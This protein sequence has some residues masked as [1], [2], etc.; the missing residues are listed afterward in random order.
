MGEYQLSFNPA[1]SRDLLSAGEA[2]RAMKKGR[3]ARQRQASSALVITLLGIVLLTIVVVAF[4]QT[5]S[6][7]LTTAKSYAD[8]RRATL[9]AQAG[10]DTAVAQISLAT[11]TNLA[12]V[13]GLTNYP[14]PNF[15]LTVIGAGNLTN[16]DQM[17][18]MVSGPIG[19]LTTFGVPGFSA[20]FN[21]Y[22]SARTNSPPQT[23]DVNVYTN[24]TATPYPYIQNINDTNMYRAAWVTMTNADSTGTQV[25]YTRFAYIVLDDTA[26]MNP[27][28]MTGT[29]AGY[30]NNINWYSGPQ[31]MNITYLTNS[32]AQVLSAAQLAQVT[33]APNSFGYSDASLGE[34]FGS[35][36]NYEAVKNYLT[37]MT[38]AS[39][40]VI[41]AW[42]PDGGMPKYN[43]NDLAT[44]TAYGATATLRATNIAN[45]I[46]RD[47]PN[48]H[49][50]DAAYTAVTT[51]ITTYVQHLAD[52][53]VDYINP[54]GTYTQ[55]T[56][57]LSGKDL[58]LSGQEMGVFP[59]MIAVRWQMSTGNT[60]VTSSTITM[61]YYV[62]AW[63]PYTSP[64]VVA[65]STLVVAN[66]GAWDFGNTT[67]YAPTYN[68]TTNYSTPLIVNP[69][70]VVTFAYPV[71]TWT[72]TSSV[73]A[74]PGWEGDDNPAG[75]SGMIGA[76]DQYQMLVNG[77]LMSQSQG[78]WPF[79][80]GASPVAT[81]AGGMDV[82]GGGSLG[83]GTNNWSI[84]YL[85]VKSTEVGDPRFGSFYQMEWNEQHS[86]GYEGAG[87][88]W[89]GITTY[90]GGNEAFNPG[91]LWL[92]RDPVPVNPV[93]GVFAT[94]YNQ[95]P[96]TLPNP[97]GTTNAFAAPEF[98]RNG[99]MVS[100]GE[101]GHV[102]DPAY[103][104]DNQSTNQDG[105]YGTP[106]APSSTS[107]W[108]PF[109]V[110]GGR[111]LRIGR[112]D[113]PPAGVTLSSPANDW[114]VPGER[115]Q[116]LLD[117]FTINNANTNAAN[118]TNTILQSMTSGGALGRINPNTASTN[119]LAAVLSGIQLN[120]STNASNPTIPTT[121][122]TNAVNVA[123]QI[124]ANRPYSSLSDFYTNMPMLTTNVNYSPNWNMQYTNGFAAPNVV[125]LAA[126][127]VFNRTYQ[128]LFGKLVQ[129]LTVQSRTYRI[130][131]IGQVLDSSQ[132]PHGSVAMEAGVYLQYNNQTTPPS[133]LPVIQYV[134]IL[135]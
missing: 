103:A 91:S 66:R 39:F 100:I 29:G 119:V 105:S 111:S 4:M 115:A 17:M 12:F 122:F 16:L 101:L 44:N 62:K 96:D 38:N 106:P 19:Y 110:G 90:D 5:T 10:L 76:R 53:M 81:P 14:L 120:S 95:T 116:S 64:V 112:P 97:Y 133:Y 57:G 71:Q 56:G 28:L 65:N 22:A 89:N 48:F 104:S 129:H 124:V 32:G 36:A 55:I 109:Q 87:A 61:Q 6:L 58:L 107:F 131:V 117:L 113:A 93:V 84:A 75:V 132:K 7:S 40:D 18:P 42:Y 20:S 23:V 25:N 54:D 70:Q 134:R 37:S 92:Y 51:D 72:I 118:A 33:A 98:V 8:V 77:R 99:P 125:H 126:P 69:N 41:P 45:I 128:E 73:P 11:G 49:L 24:N 34:T 127:A 3:L 83:L 27:T 94:D 68:A 130:Y 52:C 47:L 1:K 74:V 30:T 85:P 60:K 86:S 21:T 13:T 135:K 46:M 79:T 35:R 63:N 15:P 9:A 2:P 114:N 123:A 31:D 67:N 43:I 50:R 78:P 102:F 80:S 121:F 82:A 59:N 108:S 26:R 88:T